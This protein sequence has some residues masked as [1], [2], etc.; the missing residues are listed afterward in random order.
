MKY[1]KAFCVEI[2]NLKR[3]TE[4]SRNVALTSCTKIIKFRKKK[5]EQKVDLI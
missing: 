2:L 4:S 5:N 3:P 1:K